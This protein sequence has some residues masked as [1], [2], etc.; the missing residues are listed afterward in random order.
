[1][2]VGKFGI[3]YCFRLGAAHPP[4]HNKGEVAEASL[5]AKE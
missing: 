3:R 5:K 1:M 2:S 4:C